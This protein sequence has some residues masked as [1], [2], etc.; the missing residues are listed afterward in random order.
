M[1]IEKAVDASDVVVICLSNQS[2]TKEGFVQRE[3]RYAYDLAFEKPE[4]TIFLI[5]LRLDDCPVPRKLRT[6]HWVDYFG[7]QKQEAYSDLL[8]ALQLRYDQKMKNWKTR[9]IERKRARKTGKTGSGGEVRSKLSAEKVS[10]ENAEREVNQKNSIRTEASKK[11]LEANFYLAQF[12]L[13]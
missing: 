10:V 1:V 4:D 3:I 13:K 5:P 9:G 11:K 2:V 7:A 12:P 6:I 8:E